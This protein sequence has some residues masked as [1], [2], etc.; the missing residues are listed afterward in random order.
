MKAPG[1]KE[2]AEES[3][4]GTSDISGNGSGI[5]T[6]SESQSLSIERSD[7]GE[8]GVSEGNEGMPVRRAAGPR[9]PEGKQKSKYNAT[10]HGI[11]CKVPVLEGESQA[12]FD[13][14]WTGLRNDRQPVG[15][16]E[17]L[18][19][20]MLVT[21]F[22]R[23]RRLIVFDA[24]ANI[25]KGIDLFGL[26]QRPDRDLLLRYESTLNRGIDR[27]LAQ[28]ERFQRMRLGQPVPPRIDVN[29]STS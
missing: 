2:N 25:E 4:P 21:D 8:T 10:R 14:L 3:E 18:L 22:W 12:E 16:L 15:E 20:E 17:E 7:S 11:F 5:A 6:A 9:T 19:V 23:L 29:L 26:D 28:L 1:Q 27:A 24:K 13:A